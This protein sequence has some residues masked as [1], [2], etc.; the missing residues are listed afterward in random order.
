MKCVK[1]KV[2]FVLLASVL[3]ADANTHA[4]TSDAYSSVKLKKYH[5]SKCNQYSPEELR[6]MRNAIFARRGR[7]FQ[8]PE[9][10]DFFRKFDWYQPKYSLEEFNPRTMMTASERKRAKQILRCEKRRGKMS[11]QTAKRTKPPNREKPT[12]CQF[13]GCETSDRCSFACPQGTR[14]VSTRFG[15]YCAYSSNKKHGNYA[16]WRPNGR[17]ESCEIY[18]KNKLEGV[19]RYFSEDGAVSENRKSS[20]FTSGKFI[21]WHPNGVIRGYGTYA[22]R[23]LCGENYFFNSNGSPKEANRSWKKRGCTITSYGA[24][25]PKCPK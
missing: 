3:L 24:L 11:R 17:L 1:T 19:Q 15:R 14:L 7:K 4:Q 20:G 13:G 8:T 12:S 6:V 10:N 18:V 25:C 23:G 16:R 21:S 5:E 9:L 2:L 22:R